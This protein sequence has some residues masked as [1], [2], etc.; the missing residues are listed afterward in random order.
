MMVDA[1]SEIRK[2]FSDRTLDPKQ[3]SGLTL[4]FLGDT[5]YEEVNRSLTVLKGDVP[6]R[7]LHLRSIERANARTQSRMALLLEESFTEEEAAVYRRGRNAEVYTRAK[8]ASVSEY[9][10]ATGLE[11]VIGY[12]FLLGRTDRILELLKTG[13]EA[14]GV[15]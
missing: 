6:V 2:V 7:Q 14:A 15:L 3:L 1:F 12:L 13:W 4:A 8:N 11:A 9:H 10:H 5:V